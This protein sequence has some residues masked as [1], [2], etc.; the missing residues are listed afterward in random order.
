MI[1]RVLSPYKGLPKEVYIVMFSRL[2]TSLGSV[3]SPF[4]TMILVQ[5]IGLDMGTA[6]LIISLS[7]LLIIPSSMIGGYISDAYGRKM[8]F[9]TLK[10]LG[11]LVFGLCAFLPPSYTMIVLLFLGNIFFNAAQPAVSAMVAD[12]TP[13]ARLSEAYSL[14]YLVFNL[15]FAVGMFIG[16]KLFTEHL[17]LMFLLNAIAESLAFLLIFFFVRDG[18]A[19]KKKKLRR[20]KKEEGEIR[21]EQEKKVEKEGLSLLSFFLSHPYIVCFVLGAFLIRFLYG[22]WGFLMPNQLSELYGVREGAELFASI[23]MTNGIVV[24]LMT[25]LMT[26]L[27]LNQRSVNR[28][29]YATLCQII[30]FIPFAFYLAPPIMIAGIVMATTG[31]VLEVLGLSPYIMAR[32]PE[33]LRGRIQA[34]VGIIMSLGFSIS[35]TLS[36]LLLNFFNFGG[37]W[38]FVMGIAFM[39]LLLFEFVRR[40]D[41]STEELVL[42]LKE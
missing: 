11:L 12:V 28:M 14:V 36:T 16:G 19:E 4:I 15:G 1:A 21:A 33:N 41:K 20:E 25:P 40:F 22:Q 10:C 3:I 26:R 2:I 35:P 42:D 37:V 29:I 38:L 13:K 24:V 17:N 27:M 6:G 5:K 7:A 31:E 32:T 34:I 30:G 8:V 23:G 9:L 39:G 18:Y